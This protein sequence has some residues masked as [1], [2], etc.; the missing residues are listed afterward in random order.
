MNVKCFSYFPYLILYNIKSFS[1]KA[2]DKKWKFNK[3]RNQKRLDK[4]LLAKA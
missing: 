4:R 1:K 3:Q 2:Q